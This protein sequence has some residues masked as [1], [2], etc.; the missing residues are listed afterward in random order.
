MVKSDLRSRDRLDLCVETTH[1]EHVVVELKTDTRNIILVSGYRPPNTSIKLF[2]EEYRSLYKTL[3]RSK[4]YEIIMGMD[5]NID[6]LKSLTHG[7]TNQFLEFNLKK[8]MVPCVTKPTRMTHKSATLLDNI[9]ISS[10]LQTS[11]SSKILVDDISDHLPCLVT[12]KNQN[13]SIKGSRK[14]QFRTLDEKAIESIK[15]KLDT[16]LW[17][18]DLKDL[19]VDE[20]FDMFHDKLM[21][22]IDKI[23][24][25]KIKTVSRK[26][27][28]RDSWITSGLMTSLNKQRKLYRA[29]LGCGNTVSTHKYK[30]YRNLVKKLVRKSK[31]DYL[32]TKCEEYKQNGKKL[33]QLINKIIGKTSNKKHVIN[34]LRIDGTIQED[35]K[36]ISNELCNFFSSVGETYAN[37]IISDPNEVKKV[38]NM[39]PNNPKSMFTEPTS[40]NE[41]ELM[42]DNLPNKTSSGHDD[43][44][45]N[46]LK[47][48]KTSISLPLEI[49]FNKSLAQGI[50]PSRMK[51]ADVVPLHKGKDPMESTNY[52]PISLLLTISKL[53]EKIMYKQT[54]EFLENTGQIY[55]SQYGFRTAHSCEQ[56]ISELVSEILKGREEGMYTLGLFL[57]L[58]KAFDTIEH[59]V[60]L[61]K[62]FKY[63]VRGPT[64]SW[65]E[66]YLTD[67]KM[68]IKCETSSS[69]RLV[70]SDY[71]T[72]HYGTLQG[73][74]LGPLIFLIF[75]NDLY[76][77]LHHCAS[78]LF[79]DDTTLYKSH[80]NLRYLQ[81]C[82]EDE[83][84][85]VS[86]W[87]T[88]N[89]L[90]LNLDKTVC[91]LF[92]KD[93]KIEK[94]ELHVSDSI[95]ESQ[96]NTK[97]L[98]MWLDQH[99][100]WNKHIEILI[101]KLT[102]NLNLLK[103]SRNLMTTD[104]KKL[105]YHSH[106]GSH[107]QYGLLL[108]GNGSQKY[109][110]ERVQKL[111]DKC[112]KYIAN[113][114]LSNKEYKKLKILKIE[115]LVTL[116]NYTFGYKLMS[117][118]LPIKTQS[119][120]LADSKRKMLKKTHTYGTRNKSV[121]N[122]PTKASTKYLN[123]FLCKGPC[124]I[125]DLPVDIISNRNL[126]TFKTACKKLLLTKY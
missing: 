64:L 10:R 94:V 86:K 69:D 84:S 6:L 111:Q 93:T 108:W 123:S 32:R 117:G 101:L 85:T 72:L 66:S 82:L 71:K 119:I 36:L 12:L 91:V 57:D 77:H 104:T 88:T 100:S 75:T 58:S 21:E 56:A 79:A 87:F 34:S 16:H 39:I 107:I 115:Q 30:D 103:L 8:N 22:V 45:N 60:L 17:E 95:I 2:L 24:P 40:R 120:C 55:Q 61:Q 37:R 47:K 1:F 98:G 20:C 54:Y 116:A 5:H 106:I 118:L 42:I 44:S 41:I 50:F 65:F 81:W 19:A 29:Q 76:R 68:R 97:F 62:L 67:R 27:L 15:D 99:L 9:F 46:L 43:I 92:Q 18:S 35:S 126:R 102:R 78:I 63:G 33:W 89:K 38:L 121:P 109:L 4:K 90:T 3:N 80:R 48:L 13:K 52:R 114:P 122:L 113:K 51:L 26:K 25:I 96:P 105:I 110:I 14:I 73:S 112:I 125:L 70:Y 74:C 11:W 59:T 23:A 28:I 124:S 7:Q 83:I 53:L 49:V 31:Q